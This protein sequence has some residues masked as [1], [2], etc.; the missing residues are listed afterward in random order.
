MTTVW[1]H[2]ASGR[3][4]AEHLWLCDY[5]GYYLRIKAEGPTETWIHYSPTVST[6]NGTSL[7]AVLVDIRTFGRAKLQRVHAWSGSR[8]ILAQEGLGISI[9]HGL[10]L[11]LAD[12]GEEFRR[13]ELRLRQPAPLQS[14]LGISLLVSATQ[15]LDAIAVSAV[16]AVLA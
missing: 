2:G 10:P 11:H 5:L 14:A 9:P 3:L 16:G 8:Q 6:S 4:Q 13:V 15:S 7:S 1:V 12:Q